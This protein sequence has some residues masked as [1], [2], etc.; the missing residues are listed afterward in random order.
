MLGPARLSFK[1]D[2]EKE[3]TLDIPHGNETRFSVLVWQSYYGLD[4]TSH[5]LE[6]SHQSDFSSRSDAAMVFYL[7]RFMYAPSSKDKIQGRTYYLDEKNPR[8]QYV[9]GWSSSSSQDYLDGTG[10]TSTTAGSSFQLA[11]QGKTIHS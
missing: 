5:N 9:N 1:L 6:I 11:F 10:M 3:E 8:I 4:D 7:D 2:G